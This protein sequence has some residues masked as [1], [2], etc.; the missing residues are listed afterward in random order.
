[1]LNVLIADDEKLIR[2][3]LIALL[4]WS[5]F[6]M[7]VIGEANNGESALEFLKDQHV[8]FLFADLSMP[9]MDGF[10]LMKAVRLQYPH[11]WIIV[12]TCHQDFEYVQ[13][14]LRLGAIDYIVKTQFEQDKIEDIFMRIVERVSYEK[15]HRSLPSMNS[16]SL[17]GY[18][19]ADLKG[20][21][22]KEM[23]INQALCEEDSLVAISEHAW[24]VPAG[25]ERELDMKPIQSWFQQEDW[26]VIRIMDRSGN[27]LAALKDRLGQLIPTFL[28]YERKAGQTYYELSLP[29]VSSGSLEDK[30]SPVM[31]A[32]ETQEWMTNAAAYE[33]ALQVTIHNKMDPAELLRLLN[34]CLQPWQSIAGSGWEMGI[35][36]DSFAAWY[37]WKE[38]LDSLR[39]QCEEQMKKIPYSSSV[40]TTIARALTYIQEG[41]D[42]SFN[43]DELAM[44]LLMSSSYFSQCFKDI[45]GEAY[46]DYVK[47]R[48]IARTALL[49][50]QSNE[51]VYQIALKSGFKDEKYFSKLFRNQ[52]GQNPTEYRKKMQQGAKDE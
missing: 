2:K 21:Q 1:M 45:L 15:L 42:F 46:S 41:K 30:S 49:L 5:K 37:Q 6:D 22:H 26:A 10:E 48:R 14:A 52:F 51:P 43:R 25:K 35:C 50:E 9:I 31:K 29:S 47:V 11:I 17:S 13:E 28:F 38:K 33:E 32:W 23:I 36:S 12:L 16:E 44:K 39:G 20:E 27:N 34:T 18:V 4:P 7:K 19:F 3:G 24:L 40:I 8:D